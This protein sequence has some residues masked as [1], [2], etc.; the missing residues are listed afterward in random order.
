MSNIR[1]EYRSAKK[2]KFMQAVIIGAAAGAVVSL[3]DKTTRMSVLDNGKSCIGNLRGFVKNP[4]QVLSQVRETSTKVRS[5]VERISDDVSFISQ[6]V[7]EMKDI[8]AQVAQVVM[9]TK[10]VFTAENDDESSS[11]DHPENRIS[12]N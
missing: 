2:S 8:P 3:F 7:E 1:E 12:L 4:N 10:E 9:E 5:T 6:K 11:N